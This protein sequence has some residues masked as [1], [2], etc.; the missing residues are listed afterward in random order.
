MGDLQIGALAIIGDQI[1]YANARLGSRF[2]VNPWLSYNLGRHIRLALDHNFERMRV[3]DARLYTA[4]IS[5]L[6]AVYQFNV[7]TFFRTIL[8][9]V[10]YDYN[11]DNYTFEQDSEDPVQRV[12]R[13][14]SLG[15][16]VEPLAELP[17][18]GARCEVSHGL[19]SAGRPSW[20]VAGSL[21]S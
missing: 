5:Q 4:N 10:N 7:R 13:R 18:A 6:T 1:D 11:P 15:A 9:Y 3:N 2:R 20:R 17:V 16:A 21:R 12:R 14:R 19:G 8:Q